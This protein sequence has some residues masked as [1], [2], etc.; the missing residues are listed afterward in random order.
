M[1]ACVGGSRGGG[2]GNGSGGGGRGGRGVVAVAI[3]PTANGILDVDHL[4]SVRLKK[5]RV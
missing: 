1:F 5:K 2:G 3:P 4:V